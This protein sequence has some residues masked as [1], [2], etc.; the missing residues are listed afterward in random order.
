M[1]LLY[2]EKKHIHIT[3][4][5]ELSLLQCRCE[6]YDSIR[7]VKKNPGTANPNWAV[8]FGLGPWINGPDPWIF[9]KKIVDKL[10]QTVRRKL[11]HLTSWISGS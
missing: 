10:D 9:V 11:R 4:V 6:S 5:L 3:T 2:I 8:G 7:V 1:K